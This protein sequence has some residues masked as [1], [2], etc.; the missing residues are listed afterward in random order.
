MYALQ[1]VLN[2]ETAGQYVD[3]VTAYVKNAKEYYA[4]EATAEELGVKA[5][6]PQTLEITLI[7][8]TSFFIDLLTMWVLDVYKRQV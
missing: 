5:V 3:I 8:P 2:P 1:R 7:Q 4:G 6:D